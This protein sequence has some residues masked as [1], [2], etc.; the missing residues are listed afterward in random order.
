LEEAE[1]ENA[2]LHAEEL[3]GLDATLDSLLELAVT[4]S[5]EEVEEEEEEEGE[6]SDS[7]W[8]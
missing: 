7:K 4:A 8:A 5:V 6:E 3:V 2:K 1:A